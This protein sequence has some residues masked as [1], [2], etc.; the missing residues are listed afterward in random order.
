MQEH[1]P[2]FAVQLIVMLSLDMYLPV[3]KIV[4]DG[5]AYTDG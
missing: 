5:Q 4:H 1:E 3:T 2:L